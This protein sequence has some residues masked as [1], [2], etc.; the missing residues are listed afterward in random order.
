MEHTVQSL[1]DFLLDDTNGIT[2][3]WKLIGSLAPH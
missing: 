2:S 1:S 3:I